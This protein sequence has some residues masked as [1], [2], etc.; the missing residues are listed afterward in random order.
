MANQIELVT[1]YL[2]LLDE[3]YRANAKSAILREACC[4]TI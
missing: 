4:A 2:P 1:K 3:V